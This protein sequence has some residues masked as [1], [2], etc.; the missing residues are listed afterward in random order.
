MKYFERLAEETPQPSPLHPRVHVVVKI[1][2][3]IITTLRL[4]I[5]CFSP[6]FTVLQPPFHLY[7]SSYAS[8]SPLLF[9]CSA[10]FASVHSL[11]FSLHFYMCHWA[12]RDK[13]IFILLLL[14]IFLLFREVL[15]TFH[16]GIAAEWWSASVRLEFR[17]SSSSEFTLSALKVRFRPQQQQMELF[18]RS[19]KQWMELWKP[20][21]FVFRVHIVAWSDTWRMN[22]ENEKM[23]KMRS[24]KWKKMKRRI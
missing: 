5:F 2:K 3:I 20:L 17:I 7:S 16:I 18:T 10:F 14:C 15:R 19:L 13:K 11:F 22:D 21:S 1:R 9:C 24:W 4:L 6:L 12:N 23:I 8:F